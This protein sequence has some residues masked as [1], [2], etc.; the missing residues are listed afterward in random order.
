VANRKKDKK[1]TMDCK[2]IH[3]KLRI[4]QHNPR[5]LTKKYESERDIK[6]LGSHK[7]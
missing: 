4:E 6:Y 2:I 1:K 7:M 3:R 5:P